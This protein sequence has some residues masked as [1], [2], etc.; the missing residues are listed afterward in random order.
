MI[1]ILDACAVIAFLRNE[2]GSN[3]VENYL[4]ND[5]YTCYIHVINLCEV[6]YDVMRSNNKQKAD[7]MLNE[8]QEACVIFRDDIDL[9]FWQLVAQY[10]ATIRRVSLADCFALALTKLL[11][12]LLITSDHKEFDPIVPLGI[13]SITFIR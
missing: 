8:L 10:K 2:P 3:L 4:I 11:N 13:C 1:V 12:G 7:E 9:Y 5:A 6:Y